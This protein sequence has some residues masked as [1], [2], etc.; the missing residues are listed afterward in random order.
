M[1][2]SENPFARG[3]QN[4]SQ[5]RDGRTPISEVLRPSRIPTLTVDKRGFP[6]VKFKPQG[7]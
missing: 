4:F 6:V 1:V 3:Y 5:K 2:I 7:R